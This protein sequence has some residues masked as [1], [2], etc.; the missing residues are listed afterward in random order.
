MPSPRTFVLAARLLSEEARGR[1]LVSEGSGRSAGGSGLGGP[2]GGSC[3]RPS[4]TQTPL[5]AL[6]A[7][8]SWLSPGRDDDEDENLQ[9]VQRGGRKRSSSQATSSSAR[10]VSLVLNS[11]TV[12][13]LDL[14]Y[15]QSFYQPKLEILE[16]S[17]P[18]PAFA[19]AALESNAEQLAK[20]LMEHTL[21]LEW[22]PSSTGRKGG[23]L[24]LLDSSEGDL[25]VRQERSQQVD[26]VKAKGSCKL[27]PQA[28]LARTDFDANYSPHAGLFWLMLCA[29][30][31]CF[32]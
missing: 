25:A 3:D 32:L 27:D 22:T 14:S 8:D 31:A 1:L 30:L 20:A 10:E 18:V 13:M 15:V 29:I 12:D 5:L 23:A 2:S 24:P 4:F 6:C 19:K 17:R 11:Y 28:T 16:G 7:A 9:E 21:H 26:A